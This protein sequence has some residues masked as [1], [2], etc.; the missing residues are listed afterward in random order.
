MR[1]RESN[2]SPITNSLDPVPRRR[3]SHCQGVTRWLSPLPTWIWDLYDPICLA[4][5]VK[6][7]LSKLGMAR[8]TAV[9]SLPDNP[10]DLSWW[11]AARLPLGD[12]LK[13]RI[14]A[15]D[16]VVQRLRMEL[17]FLEQCQVLVC[18]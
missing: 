11:V 18:R 8:M 6:T 16:S 1:R 14:L 2:I 15:A 12:A 13:G 5:R 4:D 10:V 9:D 17:S 3:R 7:E